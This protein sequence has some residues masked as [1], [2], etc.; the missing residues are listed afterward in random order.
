MIQKKLKLLAISLCMVLLRGL[1]AWAGGDTGVEELFVVTT[2]YSVG[3]YSTVDLADWFTDNSI[4]SIHSDAVAQYYRNKI[5]VINRLYGDNIE[6]FDV[7][8][9]TTPILQ[10]STGSGSNPQHIA[11]VSEEKAYVSLYDRGRSRLYY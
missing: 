11:F 3:S 1:P 5:Y 2:D 4:G 9:L 7:S 10:F 6:V 8:D